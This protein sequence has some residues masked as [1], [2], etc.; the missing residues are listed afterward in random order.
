MPITL[1]SGEEREIN[2]QLYH[3][4]APPPWSLILCDQW[5][6]FVN[7]VRPLPNYN[8]W[9]LY[10]GDY[11]SEPTSLASGGY[12]GAGIH[13]HMWLD[14]LLSGN[15]RDGRITTS[16]WRPP[17]SY[18]YTWALQFYFRQQEYQ[19]Q[20]PAAGAFEVYYNAGTLALWEYDGLGH[21]Y[22]RGTWNNVVLPFGQWYLYDIS[23]WT[24]INDLTGGTI[25]L[26]IRI[27]WTDATGAWQTRQVD[28]PNPSFQDSDHNYVG[29]SCHS[30]PSQ[31][32]A[33]IDDTCVY[34]PEGLLPR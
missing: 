5:D 4:A 30:L 31:P 26:R 14:P 12:A 13:S 18:G 2:M 11:I 17:Q 10:S 9:S 3:S 6:N 20:P 21:S 25:T 32:T 19:A 8:Y 27:A 24:W 28:I 23:W 29:L 15:L 34:C 33:L 16:F 7:W 1:G 22:T